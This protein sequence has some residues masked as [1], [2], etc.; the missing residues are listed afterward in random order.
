MDPVDDKIMAVFQ[1][2]PPDFFGELRAVLSSFPKRK[3][4]RIFRRSAYVWIIW[5]RNLMRL[6]NNCRGGGYFF[7]NHDLQ[8]AAGTRSDDNETSPVSSW[9]PVRCAKPFPGFRRGRS[10]SPRNRCF[11]QLLILSAPLARLKR[12]HDTLS[13]RGRVGVKTVSSNP[14]AKNR[15]ETPHFRYLRTSLFHPTVQAQRRR[16]IETAEDALRRQSHGFS[17]S[18]LPSVYRLFMDI[19]HSQDPMD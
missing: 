1:T 6:W 15:I 4:R 9:K 2:L 19:C 14:S 18:S 17:N 5:I 12:L 16:Q 3:R 10:R 11:R 13:V 8:A 7:R